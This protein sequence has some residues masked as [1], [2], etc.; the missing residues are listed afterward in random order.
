MKTVKFDDI[1]RFEAYLIEAERSCGT[2]EKYTRDVRAFK[3]W[4]LE[5]GE[6][7][8]HI[9]KDAAMRWKKHL[10]QSG[11][12]PATVNSMIASLNT[13]FKFKNRNDCCIR[14]I[15]Q[16]KRFFRSKNRD[17]TKSEYEKLLRAAYRKGNEKLA[18]IMETI[19]ATGIRVSEV[20]YI[21]VD[22]A[23]SG[24]AEIY[25]KGKQRVVLMP[26]KL[27]QKLK[28]F[29]GRNEITGEI[30]VT[31]SGKS[32][33]RRQ[34]WSWMKKLCELAGIA[35]EKVFP[36]NLRHLF[37]KS[38]YEKFKDIVSLSDVLGH[39]SVE[40]T[41]IYLVNTEDEHIKKIAHLGLVL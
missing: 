1:E 3:I 36:H 35:K 24:R 40:T 2:I 4:L 33:D 26:K 9:T 13:F 10:I 37:A 5:S 19:C 29:A 15:R 7:E 34:I 39:S 22:A 12:A 30:F 20:K 16:Q 18:L 28:N 6:K 38:F 25:L 21:T 17:L 23:R 8:A 27:C 32:L 41:R 31:R 11:R 14:S